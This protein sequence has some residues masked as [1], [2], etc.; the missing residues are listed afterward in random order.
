M[1]K[2]KKLGSLFLLL[3]CACFFLAPQRSMATTS[4]GILANVKVHLYGKSGGSDWFIA[5]TKYINKDGILQYEN[6]LPGWGKVELAG[7]VDERAYAGKTFTSKMRLLDD[8]GR[9][10]KEPTPVDVFAKIG[11]LKHFVGTI[12]TDSKG[13]IVVP[14][15]M[16]GLESYLK[17]RG[18]G[19]KLDDDNSDQPVVRVNAK[20][21]GGDWFRA[22][23]KRLDKDGVLKMRNATSSKVEFEYVGSYEKISVSDLIDELNEAGKLSDHL[24]EEFKESDFAGK[25]FPKP[26]TLKVQVL[27]NDGHSI[28]K[29]TKV[30]MTVYLKDRTLKGTM[31][32]D[33]KGWL[34]V[35]GVPVD[36]ET[37][38]EVKD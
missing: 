27:D 37:K 12:K 8:K 14:H 11:G 7:N 1:N 34:K 15:S 5:K 18:K 22:L 26:F 17:V 16:V 4:G 20:M 33:S 24:A 28:T 19:N 13:W 3:F 9:K 25:S 23:E 6:V 2:K 30:R 32:T 36:V 21:E 29:P 31:K 38:M 10:I 35:K